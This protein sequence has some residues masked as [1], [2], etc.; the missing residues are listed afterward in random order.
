M[1]YVL[2]FIWILAVLTVQGQT[3]DPC[4]YHPK[5]NPIDTCQRITCLY[6]N[7]NLIQAYVLLLKSEDKCKDIQSILT[8]ARIKAANNQYEEALKTLENV[9]G[10]SKN[11]TLIQN[12]IKRIIRLADMSAKES[13][14]YIQ[15]AIQVNTPYN[16]IPGF[17]VG[18]ELYA[19]Y[20]KTDTIN[21]FPIIQTTPRNQY[22]TPEAEEKLDFGNH[23]FDWKKYP[24]ISSGVLYK[25]SLLFLT[26]LNQDGFIKKGNYEIICLDLDTKKQIKKLTISR[27]NANIMHPAIRDSTLYFVSDMEGGYGQMDIYKTKINQLGHSEFENLGPEI[28]SNANE[29]F[30]AI[31]GDTLFFTSDRLSGFGG[32]DIYK[33]SLA[34]LQAIHIDPPVNTPYDDFAPTVE[35]GKIKYFASN[36]IGGKGKNDIY[37]V[38]F[39]EPKVFFQNLVG[40]IQTKESEDL[41]AI[42]IRIQNHDGSY[43]QTT[44]LEADGSFSFNHIKGLESYEISIEGKK[45]PN[46]SRMAIFGQDGNVIKDIPISKDGAFKFE[47]LTPLDYFLERID[48]VDRSV[49]SVD[50]LGMIEVQEEIEEGFRIYLEDSDGNLIGTATTD[51]KGNFIFKAVKPT[52]KYVIKTKITNP[53]ATIHI[54]SKNGD[55][56]RSIEPGTGNDF[57]YVRLT[58]A[59]RIITLTNEFEEKIKISD[60]E[61]FNLPT[62]YFELAK[63]ELTQISKSR[64]FNLI[65]LLEKNPTI[66][67]ELSGHTDSRGSDSYNLKLSQ[68]RIHSVIN[69]LAE[70]GIQ[71][72]RMTGTGYGESK[73][74]NHCVDGV[75]CSEEEHAVNRRTEIRIYQ[76]NK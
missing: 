55:V 51:E 27:K 47:L 38:S 69:Y 73:L 44:T 57:V 15:N 59:D 65:T 31:T 74:L 54:L 2:F 8:S 16:D 72:N 12:E 10:S 58:D 71:K 17:T 1:R 32:L 7:G 46:D 14:T 36:R 40:K 66:N 45:L 3:T 70:H 19:L 25:D 43:S 21:F 67:V 4:I 6:E 13:G 53:D 5:K 63:S 28:N 41:A 60:L 18:K 29:I 64:L 62:L 33:S 34:N 42:V 52:D 37:H 11:A 76:E 22:F 24:D 56:L 30:P 48:N 35:N 39:V 75:E 9:S 20:D 50:I 68:E 26:V 23:F 61:Q 49:L